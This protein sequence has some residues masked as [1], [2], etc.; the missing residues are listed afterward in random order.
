[1]LVYDDVECYENGTVNYLLHAEETTCHRMLTKCDIS[2]ETGFSLRNPAHAEQP[3]TYR[4]Y[5]RP[6]DDE[7]HVRFVSLLLLDDTLP[8]SFD[9]TVPNWRLDVGS[10]TIYCNYRAD[11]KVVHRNGIV[12]VGG[13]VTD[14]LLLILKDSEPFAVVNGSIIRP[15]DG[16]KSP[17][18]SLW[19]ITGRI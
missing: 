6:T 4:S 1:M 11:G 10:Y 3:C 13:Y 18:E 5:N 8:V 12:T 7:G 14:A 19:R 2:E 9:E 17:L 16:S 15:T